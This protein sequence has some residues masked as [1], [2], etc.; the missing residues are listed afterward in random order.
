MVLSIATKPDRLVA[1]GFKQR[2]GL[3]YDDTF[4]LI[5]KAAII[6]LVLSL[7]LPVLFTS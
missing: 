5:V 6:R 4:S 3:D 7:S 1:E 2:Y